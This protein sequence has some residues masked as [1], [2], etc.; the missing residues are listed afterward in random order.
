[1]EIKQ[2][3]K[4][5]I[6]PLNEAEYSELESSIL[7]EG[8]REP[9]IVWNNVLVDGHNRYEICTKHNI[10]FETKSINFSDDDEAMVWIIT[11]QLGRRNITDFS[12]AELA[13]KRKEILLKQGREKMSEA[14]K[15]ALIIQKEG[16]T[17]SVKPSIKHNTQEI[18]AKEVSKTI[19]LEASNYL[20][21]I[22]EN[23]IDRNE[24]DFY[25]YQFSSLANMFDFVIYSFSESNSNSILSYTVFEISTVIKGNDY[26]IIEFSSVINSISDTIELDVNEIES[27]NIDYALQLIDMQFK[28]IRMASKK[29]VSA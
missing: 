23:A 3:F 24:I 7:A 15:E 9:L 2:E 12:R 25:N 5:L 10:P 14:K 20:I 27:Y 8:C 29:K 11:N 28:E 4:N 17:N 19:M 21:N 18:L 22:F 6:P 1:M 26:N 16:L 13:L